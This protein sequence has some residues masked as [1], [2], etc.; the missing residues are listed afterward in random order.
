MIAAVATAK[1][2]NSWPSRREKANGSPVVEATWRAT[3][4]QPFAQ[5]AN[6]WGTP[7]TVPP[8]NRMVTGVVTGPKLWLVPSTNSVTLANE[9]DCVVTRLGSSVTRNALPNWSLPR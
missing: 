2:V 7:F 4:I 6:G 5:D 1:V 9:R 3:E 8:T